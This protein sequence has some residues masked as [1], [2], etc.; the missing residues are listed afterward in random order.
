MQVRTA[1][2]HAETDMYHKT[3]YGTRY[4]GM[5][6]CEYTST[7]QGTREPRVSRLSLGVCVRTRM[8]HRGSARFARNL[9]CCCLVG[10]FRAR[11]RLL[12]C[13]SYLVYTSMLPGAIQYWCLDEYGTNVSLQQSSLLIGLPAA[14]ST[15][16][17][18]RYCLGMGFGEPQVPTV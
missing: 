8:V 11:T 4:H 16:V 7:Q 3:L 12:R 17:K 15:L 5:H 2:T 9:A 1:A 10:L 14:F 18:N 6:E 13:S